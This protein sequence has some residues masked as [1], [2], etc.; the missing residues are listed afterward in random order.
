MHEM[1]TIAIDES[2]VCQSVDHATG[3]AKTAEGIDFLLGKQK[4]LC[5]AGSHPHTARKTWF[6][7]A[8]V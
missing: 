2:G 8:F 4:T 3:C 6:D 5:Y 1:Q 7:A